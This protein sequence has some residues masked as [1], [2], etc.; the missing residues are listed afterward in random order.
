[1]IKNYFI[2]AIRNLYKNRFYSI[3]NILGLSVGIASAILLFIFIQ[4]ELS[5]DKFHKDADNIY[6]VITHMQESGGEEYSMSR[7][8]YDT[9]PALTD[10]VP[11]VKSATRMITWYTGDIIKH[12]KEQYEGTD[13]LYTDSC[14]LDVF[15]FKLLEGSKE[16]FLSD[17]NGA[18]ITRSTANKLFGEDDPIGKLITHDTIDFVVEWI[19]EDVPDN[20]HLKFDVL[21]SFESSQRIISFLSLDLLT[22]FKINRT[23]NENS[24]N[25]INSVAGD[26]LIERFS[27]I[28]ENVRS[29]IQPIKDIHLNGTGST[30]Q[31]GSELR[32]IYIFTFLALFII[33]IAVMNFVNL[34]TAR[35]E[36]RA[37]EVGI[38]KVNGARKNDL[39]R[40]FLGESIIIST[41]SLFIALVLAETFAH[42]FGN[43][44]NRDL[45]LIRQSSVG[46]FIGLIILSLLIGIIAGIYPA[47]YISR[48]KTIRCIKGLISSK[49]NTILKKFLVVL[50]FSIST[51]LII[52]VLML[53]KQV[54]F[55]KNR[56]LG[57]DKEN[58]IVYGS[59]TQKIQTNL[60][61]IRNDLLSYPQIISVCGS[62]AIPGQGRSGQFIFEEGKDPETGISISENRIQ[63]DYIK[64]YGMKIIDG[65]D[66]S[67]DFETDKNAF[68][69]N[70]IAV[71]RLGIT[72]PVG[73]TVIVNHPGTIIG[74][75]KDFHFFSV[76]REINPLVLTKYVDWFY[77][78]SIRIHPENIPETKTIIENIL[79]AYDPDYLISSSFVNE[80][81]DRMYGAEVNTN[82]LISVGSVLA[83]IIS[84]LGL[85]ALTSFTIIKSTKQIGIRK[86]LGAPVN[87][88]ILMLNKN[89]L[90]WVVFSNI[91]AWP[92]AY[93]FINNWL[94]SFAYKAR[95]SVDLFIWGAIISLIFAAI[96]ISSQAVKA[97]RMNPVDAIRYE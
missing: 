45:S 1:M 54:N 32:L 29:T 10:N 92:A 49:G 55:M 91:I 72:D 24:I 42:P 35:S 52:C 90:R 14:F 43:L 41:I 78:I 61:N 96:T 28:T 38:R 62:Q 25:K 86:A 77:N 5:Y 73:K 58:I 8:L 60:E 36:Y 11:E 87:S 13:I 18:A 53:F 85:F 34:M 15:D 31:V 63:N 23:L 48:F 2:T 81:F 76:K 68:I 21:V 67:D 16:N 70:E 33:I 95:I 50:Q 12:E 57:F 97:A 59:A 80:N 74:V 47:Y 4:K 94:Q 6:R 17:P 44:L 27:R 82:K 83:I 46:I 20:S 51:F 37:K 40:Q 56:D 71:K 39:L 64:T 7:S 79:K 3:I 88:I 65:R 69:L 75:V 9:G 19:L 22:Y 26:L 30:N 66:F 89:V 84:L 93:F